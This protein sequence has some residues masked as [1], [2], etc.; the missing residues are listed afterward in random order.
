MSKKE[1]HSLDVFEYSKETVCP[2]S[3]R[4]DFTQFVPVIKRQFI[5]LGKYSDN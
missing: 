2:V 5:I 1:F 4:Y 3:V